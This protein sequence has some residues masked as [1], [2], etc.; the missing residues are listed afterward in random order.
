[1]EIHYRA[2]IRLFTFRVS[3]TIGGNSWCILGVEIR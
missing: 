2:F 1:V 3:A